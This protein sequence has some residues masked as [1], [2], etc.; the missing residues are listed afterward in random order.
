MLSEIWRNFHASMIEKVK[1]EY[2]VL[3]KKESFSKKVK[4]FIIDYQLGF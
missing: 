3:K 1:G 4:K 2:L